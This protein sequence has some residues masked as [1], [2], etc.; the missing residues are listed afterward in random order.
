MNVIRGHVRIGV[1]IDIHV[2]IRED[3]NSITLDELKQNLF[4]EFLNDFTHML[5]E[6][7]APPEEATINITG[8]EVN[9]LRIEDSDNE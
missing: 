2:P 9:G 6:E 8:Y 1:D 3:Q 7:I 5:Q 4:G